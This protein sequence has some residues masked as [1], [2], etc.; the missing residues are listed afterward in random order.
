MTA[1]EDD[2]YFVIVQTTTQGWIIEARELR[3]YHWT[4]TSAPATLKALREEVR[5]RLDTLEVLLDKAVMLK[6]GAVSNAREKENA[7]QDAWDK[8]AD[9][10][11]RGTREYEGAQERYAW[12]RLECKALLDASRLAQRIQ[13]MTRDAEERIR[14]AY[15]GLDKLRQDMNYALR[16]L[17]WEG[18]HER[19]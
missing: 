10:A 2:E 6:N 4:D 7:Y 15:Q 9:T 8:K 19:T 14:L 11:R 1:P 3:A 5:P 18:A 12:Y 17:N 13:E 16:E